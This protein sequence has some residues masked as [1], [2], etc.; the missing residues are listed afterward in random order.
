MLYVTLCLILITTD[1]RCLS[2]K[3]G[4]FFKFPLSRDRWELNVL[5]WF[6][7]MPLF[8]NAERSLSQNEPAHTNACQLAKVPVLSPIMRNRGNDKSMWFCDV[9]AVD[10]TKLQLCKY[11][12]CSRVVVFCMDANVL[13]YGKYCPGMQ[14]FRLMK[15]AELHIAFSYSS[16]WKRSAST[17]PC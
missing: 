4:A 11:P 1:R 9:M 5:G 3:N 17:V 12:Y 14:L 8:H 7:A 10:Q 15:D 16:W 13:D 6:I 2:W